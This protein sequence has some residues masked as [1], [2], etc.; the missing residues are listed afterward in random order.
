M[1]LGGAYTNFSRFRGGGGYVTAANSNF[2]GGGGGDGEPGSFAP[3]QLRG[4]RRCREVVGLT[5]WDMLLPPNRGVWGH[6]PPE[7]FLEVDA[8]RRILV[9]SKQKIYF[10]LHCRPI[11]NRKVHVLYVHVHKYYT[12]LNH[13]RGGAVVILGGA[14]APPPPP[15][16]LNAAL[17]VVK[18]PLYHYTHT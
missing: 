11:S 5:V 3:V 10:T 18:S 12:K 4:V 8:L 1:Y 15:A 16:P 9:H 2:A 6:A 17:L 7:I 13:S 14:K